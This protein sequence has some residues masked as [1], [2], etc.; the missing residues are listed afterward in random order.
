M[1]R[2]R[3]TFLASLLL[4]SILAGCNEPTAPLRHDAY[5][6][7]RKWTPAVSDAVH[8]SADIMQEWRLLGAYADG[9]GHLRQTSPD[10]TVLNGSGKPVIMVVRIDGQLIRWDEDS[11]LAEIHSFIVQWRA[12]VGL[13][14]GLEIDYD[15]ATA[16]LPEYASFLRRLR[17]QIDSNLRLSVTALPAWLS[18]TGLDELFE[19]VDE[20]VLQVHAVK[21]AQEGIFSRQD[22]TTWIRHMAARIKKP[23][24]VALPAYGVRIAQ[25]EEGTVLS[26]ESEVPL[27]AGGASFTEMTVDPGQVSLLLRELDRHRP[28]HLTGIVWFRLP[29]T[30]D[31]R[32]WSLATLRA[33]IR[34]KPVESQLDVVVEDSDT[35]GVKTLALVNTGDVDARFPRILELPGE[36]VLADGIHGYSMELREGRHMLVRAQEAV[37]HEHQRMDVGWARCALKREDVHARP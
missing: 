18:S 5:I 17:A 24:R 10:W 36:C 29:I 11:L 7:Q 2:R 21:A 22:A 26:V 1:L 14:A 32:S 37:L 3:F 27:L 20:V 16:R 12:N 13:F 33:V 8:Q 9:S 30:S 6:W 19:P 34:D 25:H 15:S 23:F 31:R 28:N 35:P 4:I